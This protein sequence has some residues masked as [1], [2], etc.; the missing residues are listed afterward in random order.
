MMIM[1]LSLNDI[2]VLDFLITRKSSKELIE[3]IVNMIPDREFYYPELQ[4]AIYTNYQVDIHSLVTEARKNPK[5]ST[6]ANMAYLQSSYAT[7]LRKFV[8]TKRKLLV[9]GLLLQTNDK[10]RELLAKLIM[11]HRLQHRVLA[12]KERFSS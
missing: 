1:K 10:R 9:F 5:S 6:Q 7:D 3:T 12:L 8:T 2:Q 4:D 11:D